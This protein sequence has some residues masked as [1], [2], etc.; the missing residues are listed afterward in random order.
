MTANVKDVLA[1]C[2]FVALGLLFGWNAYAEL[3]IG[4][5]FRMGPGFFPVM[6]SGL[7]VLIGIVVAVQSIGH[8]QSEISRFPWRG[9]VLILLSPIVFGLTVRGL[10]F[11]PAVALVTIISAFA[12][13]RMGVLMALII[14]LFMTLFCTAVFLYGLGLPVR[15]FGPWLVG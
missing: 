5:T 3:D 6:L 15:P 11:I 4:T 9:L 13:T 14:T 8:E 12:S 1:G 7:L 10:G 2:V